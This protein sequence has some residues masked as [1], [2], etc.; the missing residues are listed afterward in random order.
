MEKLPRPTAKLR[1]DLIETA[2]FNDVDPQAW[3]AHVLDRIPEY[4]V[5]RID[6]LLSW[7]TAP[8]AEP[9]ADA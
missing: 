3:L 1:T 7:T 6:Q 8:A 2:R 5:N 4:K 9:K